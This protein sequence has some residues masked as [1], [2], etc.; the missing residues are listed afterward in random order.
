M[1]AVHLLDALQL[2]LG[3][4]DRVQHVTHFYLRPGDGASGAIDHFA[5][6]LTPAQHFES[7]QVERLTRRDFDISFDEFGELGALDA[8]IVL[9][10]ADIGELERAIGAGRRARVVTE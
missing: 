8:E 9:T 3:A 5:D 10:G 2:L 7:A 6:E 1:R 4:L